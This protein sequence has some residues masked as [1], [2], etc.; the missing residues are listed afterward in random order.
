[1]TAIRPILTHFPAGETGFLRAPV[2]LQ[3]ADHDL[4]RPIRPRLF[5]WL[6]T[7]R[8]GFPDAGTQTGPE[9]IIAWVIYRLATGWIG[10][11]AGAHGFP[12]DGDRVAACG[13]CSGSYQTTG[14]PVR[15]G[16]AHLFRV[17]NG[18]IARMAHTVS[19]QVVSRVVA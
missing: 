4:C 2:L 9:A 15:A 17:R 16:F 14:K 3:G 5:L 19:T 13:V 12:G 10:T 7:D 11:K 8:S 1:M 6:E 18:K